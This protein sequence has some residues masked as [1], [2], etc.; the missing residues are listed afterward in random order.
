M[1]SEV[2]LEVFDIDRA[3]FLKMPS[4]RDLQDEL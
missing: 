1:A 4:Y 2:V 3:N